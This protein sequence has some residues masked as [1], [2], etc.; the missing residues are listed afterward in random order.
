MQDS[1]WT[2]H[3]YIGS[4][5]SIRLKNQDWRQTKLKKLYYQN[6][7]LSLLVD[8]PTVHGKSKDVHG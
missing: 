8:Q 2:K 3:F 1:I 5:E 6:R 4:K 7:R